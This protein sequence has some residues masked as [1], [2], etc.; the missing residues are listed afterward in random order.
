[1]RELDIAGN[2][3]LSE[4]FGLQMTMRGQWGVA[5]SGSENALAERELS[6]MT[7]CRHDG[8]HIVY[9]FAMANQVKMEMHRMR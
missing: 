6:V 4:A 1:V 7:I 2:E 9:S 5:N 3:V 8:L